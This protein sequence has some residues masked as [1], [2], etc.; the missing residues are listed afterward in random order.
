MWG[1]NTLLQPQLGQYDNFISQAS[2]HW[3]VLGW[4]GIIK[5]S[6]SE[7]S[8]RIYYKLKE[9]I[10]PH[11][12]LPLLNWAY[13]FCAAITTWDKP[14]RMM[15]KQV[16]AE[17][18]SEYQHIP[19]G[20]IWPYIFSHLYLDHPWTCKL[21]ETNKLFFWFLIPVEISGSKWL[22]D[23]VLFAPACGSDLCTAGGFFAVWAIREALVLV[24]YCHC[25]FVR[26][27]CSHIEVIS[28]P[29][30]FIR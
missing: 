18:G 13:C 1:A 8:M 30:K 27:T 20:I 22:K 4:K 16:K 5:L 9:A 26:Q 10:L 3:S 19:D 21:C 25:D 2:F 12:S 15:A 17:L 23:L 6:E 29:I 24:S 28:C 11:W 14:E 7:A